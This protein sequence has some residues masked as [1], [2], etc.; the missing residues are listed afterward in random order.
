MR[1]HR[2]PVKTG[3]VIFVPAGSIHALGPGIIVAEIQQNS[4]TTYRIYDWGRPRPIHVAQALDVLDFSLVEPGP[5]E[6]K[7]ITD[8][9]MRREG[10]GHCQY[11]HTERLVAQAGSSFSG[12][13]NGTTFEVWAVLDGA[14]RVEWSGTPLTLR[15]V[16]WVLLPAALG[17]F[18]VHITE[19]E[20]PVTRIYAVKRVQL[21]RQSH[22]MVKNLA[23]TG[24]YVPTG[25]F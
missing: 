7:P 16:S 2:C 19:K 12:A 6:P 1:S 3:D 11:F 5:V 22:S 13:C 21:W 20:Y 25:H 17:E 9:G 24:F 10:I 18:A 4:D 8:N 15:G 23:V 14:M